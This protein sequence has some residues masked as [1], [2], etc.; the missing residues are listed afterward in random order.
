MTVENAELRPN[1]K[2]QGDMVA[3]VLSSDLPNGRRLGSDGELS[4][5]TLVEIKFLDPTA[6]WSTEQGWGSDGMTLVDSEFLVAGLD[7]D[8][9]E[10]CLWE[11]S[12]SLSEGDLDTTRN[13][14]L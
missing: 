14:A 9:H 5:V 8:F 11:Q 6:H 3:A 12:I 10:S 2:S 7:C 4:R 13:S 1:Q